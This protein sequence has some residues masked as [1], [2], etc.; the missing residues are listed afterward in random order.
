MEIFR[1]DYYGITRVARRTESNCKA[2]AKLQKK[3]KVIVSEAA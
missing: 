1:E 2:T 3:S